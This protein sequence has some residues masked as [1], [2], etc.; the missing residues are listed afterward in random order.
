MRKG[1][2]VWEIVGEVV[3]CLGKGLLGSPA[4][5]VRLRELSDE[6]DE[7]GGTGVFH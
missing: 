4:E 1:E 7:R 5:V 2:E 6:K 3:D